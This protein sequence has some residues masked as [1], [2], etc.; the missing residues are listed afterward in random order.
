MRTFIA[1]ELPPQIKT[2][3]FKLQEQ[4]KQS[5]ADVKWVEPQNI[6]LTLKFLG[7]V[8]EEKITKIIQIIRDVA[9]T[10]NVFQ[11]HISSLGAFPKISFPRVIWVGINQGDNET[12]LI[13]KELEEKIQKLGI[14]KEE[15]AFSSHI[16][17]ARVKSPKNKD[18]LVQLLKSLEG[19]LTAENLGFSVN[20]ITL[21]R[22]ILSP[23]GPTYEI[24]EAVN[25]KTT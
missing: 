8:E 21:F 1:I 6:H 24:L 15:K 20:K 14:P 25:L 9:E 19:S 23:K 3:L 16:T 22:S 5:G 7:E 12:K 17:L 18:K 2:A 13:V 4:L 10:N 11:A